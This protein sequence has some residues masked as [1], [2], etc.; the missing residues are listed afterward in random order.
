M[1]CVGALDRGS[2]RPEIREIPLGICK[3][4]LSIC[5]KDK[6]LRAW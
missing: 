5:I 1:L 6:I 4:I 3:Y 2:L